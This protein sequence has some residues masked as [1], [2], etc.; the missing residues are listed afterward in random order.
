MAQA[1]PVRRSAISA[2]GAELVHDPIVPPLARRGNLAL[3]LTELEAWGH[4][5]G[6]AAHPPLW[7]ALS[8]D[9]GSGK[10]T[11]VRAICRGYGVTSDVTS[12]TFALVHE[13]TAQ[14]SRVFHLD[15]YRLERH[16]E[17]TTLGW[18]DLLEEVA[19]VLVEWPERARSAMPPDRV[20]IDLEHLA[21]DP[22]RRLLLTG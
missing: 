9:L 17:L 10:T 16:D 8:G 19:L 20:A 13:Y 14:R 7:V 15:L 22:D 4:S 1:W 2:L 3:T 5:F 11:L 18:Y 6:Q 21:G 12:P